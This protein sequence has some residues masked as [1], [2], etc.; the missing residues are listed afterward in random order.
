MLARSTNPPRLEPHPRFF[1]SAETKST[2]PLAHTLTVNGDDVAEAIF[3]EKETIVIRFM[4][5]EVAWH[6]RITFI[7]RNP[8]LSL[9]WIKIVSNLVEIGLLLHGSVLLPIQEVVYERPK[10]RLWCAME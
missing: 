4:Q 1:E 2:R 6:N 3:D 10:S 7:G 8:G 5:L 9:L